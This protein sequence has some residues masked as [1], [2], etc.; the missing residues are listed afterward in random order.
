MIEYLIDLNPSASCETNALPSWSFWCP[1]PPPPGCSD[2]AASSPWFCSTLQSGTTTTV[3]MWTTPAQRLKYSWSH[4]GGSKHKNRHLVSWRGSGAP[5]VTGAPLSDAHGDLWTPVFPR[6]LWC[7]CTLLIRSIWACARQCVW[8]YVCMHTQMRT[9]S[10]I[11]RLWASRSR[12]PG[13]PAECGADW[14]RPSRSPWSGPGGCTSASGS[15]ARWWCQSSWKGGRGTVFEDK[16]VRRE[17]D[18]DFTTTWQK[19][20]IVSEQTEVF[21]IVIFSWTLGWKQERQKQ[22]G[23]EEERWSGE[24]KSVM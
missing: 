22:R 3:S 5:A 23:R 12:C 8:I 16:E 18:R 9:R 14:P 15:H 7:C 17:N 21:K 10:C 6:Q 4:F 20:V 11:P 24:I 2:S 1:G 13:P 19:R